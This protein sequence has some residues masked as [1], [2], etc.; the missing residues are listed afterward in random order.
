[1]FL[2]M[3]VCPCGG[4]RVCLSACWDTTPP[5]QTP[6][7][8]ADPPPE[9]T[10]SP[11]PGADTHHPR[12]QTDGTHPTGMHSCLLCFSFILGVGQY[13]H[14]IKRYNDV[15]AELV[16]FLFLQLIRQ[17]VLSMH[18]KG[19]SSSLY[20]P[21]PTSSHQALLLFTYMPSVLLILL[22]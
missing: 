11:P 9:Q 7:P 10:P 3:S 21:L 13:E 4:A 18:I 16:Y 2:H 1:M 12:E 17:T 6:P 22:S 15:L 14:T 19:L 20:R 5:E 8:G